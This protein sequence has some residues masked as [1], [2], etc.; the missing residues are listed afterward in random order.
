ML[1]VLNIFNIQNDETKFF[2]DETLNL[3]DQV[4]VSADK[5]HFSEDQRD[6]LPAGNFSRLI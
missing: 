3:Q 5:S 2:I 1:K 4:R 6:F